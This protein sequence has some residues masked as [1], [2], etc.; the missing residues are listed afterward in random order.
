MDE[1][2]E[3]KL[4]L[5]EKKPQQE[6]A[7]RKTESSVHSNSVIGHSLIVG[8]HANMNR[9]DF[10]KNGTV[11]LGS[12]IAIPTLITSC[13][14]DDSI[15]PVI[16]P[17]ACAVSPSEA[18]GPFP[19]KTPADW[20]RENI[21]GDRE[22]I[23]LMITVE[24]EDANNDCQPLEGVLVDIWHCD[25]TGNYSEYI[26]QIDGD[27][28][29]QHFL[30]GRQVSD[31]NGIASF[32]SIYPGWYPG[33]APHLHFEIKSSSGLSLLITQTA[34]PEDISNTV[35]ATPNYNGN[36]NTSNANDVAFG[37]SLDNNMAS[38][39]TGNITDGY[40]LLATIK[41]AG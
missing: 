13:N 31:A 15:D 11:V 38:S 37:N 14:Q 28:T 36:F 35:Y 18:A 41:V 9:K 10:L 21:I 30:R 26:N 17:E 23:P 40:T 3:R 5:E 32:I 34:F 1:L 8:D 25:A 29:N 33:R 4:P 22:G 7:K 20:V 27:F 12:I 39:V 19:I 6:V 16:D 2:E 24:V